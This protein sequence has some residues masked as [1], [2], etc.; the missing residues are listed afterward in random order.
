MLWIG[1]RRYSLRYIIGFCDIERFL[2]FKKVLEGW[3]PYL[4]VMR[5]SYKEKT[6]QNGKFY[7]LDPARKERE[8][9]VNGQRIKSR[10]LKIGI[11]QHIL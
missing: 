7:M 8:R 3:E 6:T 9:E 11:L 4:S 1:E 10:H 2:I 5:R